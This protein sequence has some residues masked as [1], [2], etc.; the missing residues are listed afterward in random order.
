M[1]QELSVLIT[2]ESIFKELDKKVKGQTEYKRAMSNLVFLHHM[3]Q[4][5]PD[6]E[7]PRAV[8][9]VIGSTGSGKTYMLQ[10]IRE[11]FGYPVEIINCSQLTPAGWAGPDLEDYLDKYR[12]GKNLVENPPIVM[13][14][15]F[16]KIST[17]YEQSSP[18]SPGFKLGMQHQI[19]SLLEGDSFTHTKSARKEAETIDTSKYTFVLAGTFEGLRETVNKL[20]K[21]S[22]S[23]S[24]MGFNGSVE[25]KKPGPKRSNTLDIRL[26]DLTEL[27]FISEIAGRITQIV[28]VQTLERG[29]LRKILIDIDPH[30][31]SK[32]T[33]LVSKYVELWE[34]MGYNLQFYGETIDKIIDEALELNTGAR[35]LHTMLN[36][37][38]Q[39][40]LFGLK[41]R[42]QGKDVR[43]II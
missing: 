11:V 34:T 41:H 7:L 14:D 42:T 4:A 39:K 15:E 25:S 20:R 24:C 18:S 40:H 1:T 30:N 28:H 12:P 35:S 26:Q 5:H 23:K 17:N 10:T 2:P 6:S 19:L 38:M 8:P 22:E 13:L 16:D 3:R 36:K 31:N 27:G 37:F 43:V 9:I 29:E 21:T 33:G 32:V